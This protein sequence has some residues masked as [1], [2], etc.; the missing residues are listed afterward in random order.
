V[1]ARTNK[2]QIRKDLR[3]NGHIK[4]YDSFSCTL[5]DIA[6]ILKAKKIQ[7]NGIQNPLVKT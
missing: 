3:M 6:A 4:S 7:V 5:T 1:L 2:D